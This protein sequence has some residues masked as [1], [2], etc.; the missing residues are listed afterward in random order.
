MDSHMDIHMETQMDTRMCPLSHEEDDM[1]DIRG[2]CEK[3]K[4]KSCTE[5]N[6]GYDGAI[7][8]KPDS[9][10]IGH[11]L[12][13]GGSGER[14]GGGLG[15]GGGGS[16]SHSMGSKYSEGLIG[17]DACMHYC[18]EDDSD[19]QNGICRVNREKIDINYR[20][21]MDMN[22]CGKSKISR[23]MME[24]QLRSSQQGL[25]RFLRLQTTPPLPLFSPLGPDPSVPVSGRVEGKRER[26]ED[27]NDQLSGD[28]SDANLSRNYSSHG[29]NDLGN[30]NNN[31]NGN[32]SNNSG[33]AS[34]LNNN[35][36]NN[37]SNSGSGSSGTTGSSGNT[38]SNGAELLSISDEEMLNFPKH[39]TDAFN[40]GDYEGLS[41]VCL[42]HQIPPP[43]ESG[44]PSSSHFFL[45]GLLCDDYHVFLL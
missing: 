41:K 23:G 18:D 2:I 4:R 11:L 40:I 32:L 19:M 24:G 10:G 12:L 21:K 28:M 16:V 5:S 30:N 1:R 38:G 3:K 6:F 35:N 39:F 25:Q 37:S 42:L 27:N 45:L 13:G 31:N 17:L 33:R 36:N 43:E 22:F 14:L 29:Q 9:A 44:G 7:D 26:G 20:D 15:G 34:P 8:A